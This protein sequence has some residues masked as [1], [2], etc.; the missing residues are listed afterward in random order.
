[1][2]NLKMSMINTPRNLFV[3]AVAALLSAQTYSYAQAP[4]TLEQRKAVETEYGVK[5]AVRKYDTRSEMMADLNRTGGEYYMYSF[6]DVR[7][8]PAPKGYKPVYISHVGRHGARYA[9]ADRVYETLHDLF[10]DAKAKDKLTDEG[11]DLCRRYEAFYPSVAHRGGDLTLKGQNQL[12]GIADVMYKS[13]PDVF[14]GKTRAEV[15]STHVPRVMMSMVSFIDELRTLDNDITYD[16]ECGKYLLPDINPNS[17]ASP[18]RVKSKVSAKGRAQADSLLAA[19]IDLKGFCS[20]F[21]NDMDYL[22]KAYGQWQFT[23]DLRSVILDFQ[24]MDTVP[25]DRFEDIFTPEQFFGIWEAWNFNGY[26]NMGR[27]PMSDGKACLNCAAVLRNI[28][29]RA[30]RDLASGNVQLS[31]RFTHDIA[32]LPMASYMKLDN[33]GAV[34]SDPGD[35]KNWWR[36]DFIPMASNVQMIFYRSRK[37]PEILVKVLYNGREASLPIPQVAPSFYSWTAFKDY[38]KD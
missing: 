1:M 27:S 4:A 36:C 15:Q 14:K 37:N 8:S 19:N 18:T 20:R 31:L 32:V 28:I 5:D 9:T 38:Y 12:R 25:E 6:D 10:E 3:C 11:K 22:G 35:V 26:M 34:V 33:F 16:L 2:S 29:D 7:L 24:C 17:S 23:V 21:F 13:F 30:D